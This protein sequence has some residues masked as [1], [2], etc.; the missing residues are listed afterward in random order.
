MI[1]SLNAWDHQLFWWI[2][3]HHCAVSDWVLW[4]FSQAWSWPL[5]ILAAYLTVCKR[6][7]WKH[8]LPVFVGI[9]LC[10]LLGDRL[11]VMCFKDNVMRLRP[12][13]EMEGVRM[14]LTRCGGRYGFVS[15]HAANCTAVAVFLSLLG[16]IPKPGRKPLKAL[17][18][19]MALWV[20]IVGYSR[21]YLGKHFPGDVVCGTLLGLGIG[22][23]LYFI[24]CKVFAKRL[25]TN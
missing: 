15:S 25:Q 9:G 1:E 4:T 18:Y 14:F 16:S 13:H 12:C 10:F 20:L 3:S 6:L 23:L 11:S 17:P 22:A 19:L 7:G 24:Y 5:V 8:L 2:N 21:P